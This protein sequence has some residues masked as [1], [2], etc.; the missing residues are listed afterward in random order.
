MPRI[1]ILSA[2]ST[3]PAAQD[4]ILPGFLSGTV[5]ALVSPGGVGKS[6]F[7]LQLAAAVAGGQPQANTTGLN[8][9]EGGQVLYLNLED[10]PDEIC[11]RLFHLG[12]RLDLVSRQSVAENL[13]LTARQ[14]IPTDVM[15]PKFHAALLKAATGK[16]LVI[17]DTLSRCHKLEENDNGAM[18]TLIS[19]LETVPR[20]TGAALLF[21]HHTSKASA[22]A[23]QGAMQQAARG[24]S[25][26]I[27]NARY[28]ATLV[29][30]TPEDAEKWT[31]RHDGS[32]IEE[33]RRSFFVRYETGKVNYGQVEV[34]HWFE[35]TAG[36]ILKPVVLGPV[37][38]MKRRVRDDI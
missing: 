33:K 20:Q 15:Q 36:G 17:V 16:R 19:R 13:R 23:G 38:K 31:D 1:D 34:G 10:P 6:F 37:E 21:L 26:L 3:E 24:A 18:S 32:P 27:D 29:R 28:S 4:F 12:Q 30:M 2:F 14:G 7:A 35:R 9:G 22:L 5:G 25:A 8:V 11:R